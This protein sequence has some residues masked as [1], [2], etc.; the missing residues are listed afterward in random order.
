MCPDIKENSKDLRGRRGFRSSRK[1][2]VRLNYLNRLNREKSVSQKSQG[3]TKMLIE[4]TE[5]MI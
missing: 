4:K 3:A 1:L 2:R 5:C